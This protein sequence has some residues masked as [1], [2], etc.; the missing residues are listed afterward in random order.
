M[1][2]MATLR[3]RK[4]EIRRAAVA[5]VLGLERSRRATEESGLLALL[6]G[7]PGFSQARTILLYVS[8][9]PEEIATRPYIARCLES[10]CKVVLPRI[11][12][13]T[14]MLTLHRITSFTDDLR[15]GALGILEPRKSA[16][17]VDPDEVDWA[18]VPGLAFDAQRRRVGRGAGYYDRLLPTLRPDAAKIALILEAQW[19]D[20]IPVEAHD[21]SLDAVVSCSRVA[22]GPHSGATVTTGGSE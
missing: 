10:S 1:I 5:R 22:L 17:L 4:S 21:V 3:E 2:I 6:P 16:P 8:A 7:L 12:R 19:V 13:T 11:N 20:E 14:G 15:A 9:F 18:L